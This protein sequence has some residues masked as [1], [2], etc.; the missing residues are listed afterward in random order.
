[1]SVQF[2]LLNTIDETIKYSCCLLVFRGKKACHVYEPVRWQPGRKQ[3]M[4]PT[5]RWVLPGDLS[6]HSLNVHWCISI[7]NNIIKKLIINNTII[8][9]IIIVL[10]IINAAEEG[11][12]AIRLGSW[13]FRVLWMQPSALLRWSARSLTSSSSECCL[14]GVQLW[15]SFAQISLNLAFI[16]ESRYTLCNSRMTSLWQYWWNQ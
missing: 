6:F 7:N 1:M 2:L 3:T 10:F 15:S 12:A 16:L 4:H 9:F 11:K 8:L 5:E 13:T 14:S